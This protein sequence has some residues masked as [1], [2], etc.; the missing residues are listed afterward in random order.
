MTA[1]LGRLPVWQAGAW[2]WDDVQP[3]L[4]ARGVLPLRPGALWGCVL[5]A[6]KA[7][8]RPV[9]GLRVP[10]CVAVASRGRA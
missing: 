9:A 6:E 7:P 2:V 3:G 8:R 1:A 5:A 10:D 4:A